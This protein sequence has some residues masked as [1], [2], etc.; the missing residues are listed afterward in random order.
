M[1]PARF[2][3]VLRVAILAGLLI[4]LVRLFSAPARLVLDPD[5]PMLRWQVVLLAVVL[6][7][8]ASPPARWPARR[9]AA[10]LTAPR[11]GP[12]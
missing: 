4:A 7:V 5:A 2:G 9:I 12:P 3:P 11:G 10:R 6:S 1:I 8:V